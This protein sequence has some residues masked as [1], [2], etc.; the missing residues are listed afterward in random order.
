MNNPIRSEFT[1]TK[2]HI[3]WEEAVHL[4]EA[5]ETHHF[6]NDA[7]GIESHKTLHL[8]PMHCGHLV[9]TA[10]GACSKCSALIC[11]SCLVMCPLCLGPIGPC[12]SRALLDVRGQEIRYCKSCYGKINRQRVLRKIISGFIRF[13]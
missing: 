4:S 8:K 3:P 1:E 11:P 10:G 2:I 12:C 13:D 6:L 9:P 5:T 7:G